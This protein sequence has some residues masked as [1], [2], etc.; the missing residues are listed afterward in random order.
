[1]HSRGDSPSDR[2]EEAKLNMHSD[3]EKL[4]PSKQNL[5]ES[6]VSRKL[7]REVDALESIGFGTQ[8]WKVSDLGAELT[9]PALDVNWLISQPLLPY[10]VHIVP[11]HLL[12]RS[13]TEHGLED[14]LEVIEC[15]QGETLIRLLDYDLWQSP[16]DSAG[17]LSPSEDLSPDRF[18]QWVKL[19]NEVAPDFAAERLLDLEE[20]VIF[21][22]L[23]AV[24]EIV[25]V[26]LN[27][28]QEELNDDYW[29][30]PDNKFGLKLKTPD[31]AAF[32]VVYGLVHSLYR[33]DVRL[34]QQVLAHSAML[35]RDEVIEDARRWRQGRL[36][37]QGFLQSDEARHLLLRRGQKSLQQMIQT[38]LNQRNNDRV[39]EK[40]GASSDA[41]PMPTTRDEVAISRIHD[42]VRK[43]NHETLQLEISVHLPASDIQRL[44]GH[45]AVQQEVIS[46][47]EELVEAFAEK[48][49]NDCTLL[50]EQLELHNSKILK[51][52]QNKNT[53]LIDEVIGLL[54]Q[55]KSAQAVEFKS[56]I[57]RIS[58]GVLA[59]FG[60]VQESTGVARV[61]HALRGAMN[62]GLERALAQPESL[63]LSSVLDDEQGE[64]VEQALLVMSVLGPEVVFQIGW[65]ALKDLAED[66]V[67]SVVAASDNRGESLCNVKLSDGEVIQLPVVQLLQGGRYLELRRWL[68]S[69]LP[70]EATS[71]RHVLLSTV[72]RLPLFPILLLEGNNVTR[73]TT[74]VRPYETMQEVEVTKDFLLSLPRII[75]AM[76]Q[77]G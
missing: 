11:T 70:V 37:D 5:N 59:A 66:A 73:G 56:R 61:L 71:L 47:E 64:S 76:S 46:E 31:E 44:I 1:M 26:G 12:Y 60:V 3:F 67:H 4:S 72:N 19:W 8:A 23:S 48:I 13:L 55:K 9:L 6:M 52:R 10:F 34:A 18:L 32:E 42:F 40:P 33:K 63:G 51:L 7:Q 35:I 29:M 22:C 16:D 53:L 39:P 58:N 28:Q 62:I 15:I 27:R 69:A 75:G 17:F 77:E 45:D 38:A 65:Q 57:A 50:L 54:A 25:P 68:Q 24:C 41:I 21:G 30:T 74:E 36:E 14:A 49:T 2:K 20:E 43:L